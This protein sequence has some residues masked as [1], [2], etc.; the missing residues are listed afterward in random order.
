MMSKTIIAEVGAEYDPEHNVLVPD[1]PL[2][3]VKGRV[4]LTVEIESGSGR[5][6]LL[7]PEHLLPKDAGSD[8]ARA[9]RDAFGRDSLEI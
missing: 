3:G 2:E 6:K 1:E 8:L 5:A 9:I 7:D 4:H